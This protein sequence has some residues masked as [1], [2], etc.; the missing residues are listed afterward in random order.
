MPEAPIHCKRMTRENPSAQHRFATP[1]SPSTVLSRGRPFLWRRRGSNMLFRPS[2]EQATR[3]GDPRL[4]HLPLVITARL[5]RVT[6]SS[7]PENL[8]RRPQPTSAGASCGGLTRPQSADPALS[9][10]DS[11]AKRNQAD[12]ARPNRRQPRL[13]SQCVGTREP[14]RWPPACPTIRGEPSA[15]PSFAWLARAWRP[16]S[17]PRPSCRQTFWRPS[18]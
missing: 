5:Q 17:S 11:D 14:I 16:T 18:F 7:W 3:H 2:P 6:R 1:N 12:Q 10:R 4:C 13:I 15:S 9:L 8:T